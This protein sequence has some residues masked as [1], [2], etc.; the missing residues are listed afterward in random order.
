MARVRLGF[1]GVGGIATWA[2]LPAL[3]KLADQAELAACADVNRERAE[4]VAREYGFGKAYD[5]A[6]AM[7]AAGGLDAVF[8][9]TP[10]R[11]HAES[12]IAALRAGVHVF[13]EKPPAMN[14]EEAQAMAEAASLAG[15]VL[16]FGLNYR[17]EPAA[18]A[19]MR[20]AEGGAFGQIYSGRVTAIRR[21]GIPSWGVFTNKELQGGGPL[22]D[23]GVHMLDTALWLMGYP[24]PDTVLGATYAEIGK[25]PPGPA[26]WGPW[27]HENFTVEDLATAMIRFKNGASL[28]LETSFAAN[29]GPMEEHGVRLQ[30]SQGGLSLFPFKAFT[31]MHG[32]LVDIA[33]AWLPDGGESTYYHQAVHFL[34]AV[35]GEVAPLVT[36]QQAIRLSQVI[37]GIY[38]SA[39]TGR[40]EPF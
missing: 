14:A 26:P 27:D 34:Q 8:V 23:I 20:F 28:L 36:P 22:I 11:F 16:T 2:H 6:A 39:E 19:A 32:T 24:E 15:K 9:C 7:L 37:D 17:F 31:E 29:I 35:R 13:C 18:Q 10:N 30:G 3:K 12:A 40:A 25:R 33:P 4:S 21:R 5:S 38:R 1:I